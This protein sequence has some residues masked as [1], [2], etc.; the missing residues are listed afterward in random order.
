MAEGGI[1]SQGVRS[2]KFREKLKGYHP[3]DVD[4]FLE[5]VAATLDAL[6]G[7]VREASAQADRAE[8]ALSASNDASESVTKTLVLAQRT[9]EMAISEAQEEAARMRAEA[10]DV[11]A[12]S[13]RVRADAMA[14]AE[15]AAA[16]LRA[17]AERERSAAA[18]QASTTISEAE[19]NA[20][21]TMAEAAERARAVEDEAARRIAAA[22]D[23]AKAIAEQ[24]RVETARF[25][26]EA[27]QSLADQQ[28]QLRSDVEDLAHYLAGERARVLDVLTTAVE[29]FGQTLTPVAP[30]GA[31]E[32]ERVLAEVR[33][34]TQAIDP[35][36]EDSWSFDP[37][38]LKQ[39]E[40]QWWSAGT[41][42]G[43]EIAGA[44]PWPGGPVAADTSAS[45]PSGE[46]PSGEQPDAEL[47][48]S[49]TSEHLGSEPAKSGGVSGPQAP[50]SETSG[51]E[52]SRPEASA[53]HDHVGQ[54][55][56]SPTPWSAPPER[57]ATADGDA[58]PSHTGE[59][60]AIQHDDPQIP[61]TLDGVAVGDPHGAA[62]E[63]DE[64]PPARLLFTLEDDARRQDLDPA[65]AEARTRK[66]LG[67][68]R[69]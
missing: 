36:P 44:S 60:S 8:A 4:G 48:D 55:P 47:L 20:E 7:A 29:H 68:R 28:R 32:I 53:S 56:W 62:L 65:S 25:A 33:E 46:Q 58:A 35:A 18:E 54:S 17:D 27:L 49:Q 9:A 14:E 66:L 13:D 39:P 61:P 37:T 3:S 52:S 34:T 40:N 30:D 11:G 45:Q 10:A 43:A 50:G 41:G 21:R 23:E 24:Q 63:T 57:V 69:I 31:E 19:A 1:T 42:D 22:E 51:P 67:R 5:E 26:Q 15:A 64:D 38:V 16:K 59:A 12:R 6:H 2:A